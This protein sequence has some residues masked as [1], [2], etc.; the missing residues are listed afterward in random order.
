MLIPLNE[1]K[2]KRVTFGYMGEY[3]SEAL[4]YE[5]M[6]EVVAHSLVVVPRK[7]TSN[8]SKSDGIEGSSNSS[9]CSLTEEYANQ[10]L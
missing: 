4:A 10:E 6:L 5:S 2:S 3:E 7:K 1:N 9:T 8:E